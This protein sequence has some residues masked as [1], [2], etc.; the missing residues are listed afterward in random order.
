MASTFNATAACSADWTSIRNLGGGVYEMVV[1]VTVSGTE[2]VRRTFKATAA[3]RVLNDAGVDIGPVPSGWASAMSTTAT[4]CDN[5]VATLASGG[6]L[7][8]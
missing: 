4:K 2:K 3:G 6:Y 5:A 1:L 8:P 7:D